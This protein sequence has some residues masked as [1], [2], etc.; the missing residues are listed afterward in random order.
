MGSLAIVSLPQLNTH[1]LSLS[2]SPT[3]T[4]THTQSEML[5]ARL[6]LYMGV[7]HLISG[8]GLTYKTA[9]VLAWFRP[10]LPSGLTSPLDR[11]SKPGGSLN[12]P[13]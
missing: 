8:R 3:H 2:L 11:Q 4:H 5:L 10:Q 13:Y 6:S 7:S 9:A 12:E 1:T